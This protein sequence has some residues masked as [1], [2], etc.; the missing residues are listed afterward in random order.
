[1]C[2]ATTW[3][4][5]A[6]KADNWGFHVS[7]MAGQPCTKMRSGPSLGRRRGKKIFRSSMCTLDMAANLNNEISYGN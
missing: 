2:G 3:N 7:A 5:K 6:A 4:P 1:M